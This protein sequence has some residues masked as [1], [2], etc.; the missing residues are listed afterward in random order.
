MPFSPA[1]TSPFAARAARPP[2]AS[3]P[4]ALQVHVH[5]LRKA[6]GA[7]RIVTR[8]PGYLVRVEPGE[9][10]SERFEQLSA[11]GAERIR[12]ALALWR[13]PALADLA[14]E[15]FAQAEASRLEEAR[16][17]AL[18][19]RLAADLDAGRH[20]SVAAELEPLVARHPLRERLRGQQMLAL[21]RCGR[22]AEA[23]QVYQD[24]RL[25]LVEELGLDP[26]KAIVE[27]EQALAPIE[28]AA[29]GV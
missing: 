29:S 25:T 8:A 10:D 27:L 16:L 20:A 22:Q 4:G 6:L 9:L 1:S 17:A 28:P 24:T 13:G 12:E 14:Y 23:L 7:D 3:A 21:Y 18:E 5:A 26:S 11:S 15:A 19:S 2:P